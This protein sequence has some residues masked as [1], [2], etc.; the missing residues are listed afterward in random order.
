MN[1]IKNDKSRKLNELA[2]NIASQK[3]AAVHK[4]RMARRDV[5][6]L[7]ASKHS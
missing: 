5:E 4:G 6:K 7:K 3:I 2:E 1:Q